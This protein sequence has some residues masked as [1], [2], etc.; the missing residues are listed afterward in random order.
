MWDA[1]SGLQDSNN[2][3]EEIQTPQAK[4][5][6]LVSQVIGSCMYCAMNCIQG[7]QGCRKCRCKHLTLIMTVVSTRS[8][9]HV[10]SQTSDC[11][12]VVSPPIAPDD[13][14]VCLCCSLSILFFDDD[15]TF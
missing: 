2:G 1:L 12:T 10:F 6:Y 13:G 3:A 9:K 4:T 14:C 5:A 8:W 7:Q 15:C 11:L